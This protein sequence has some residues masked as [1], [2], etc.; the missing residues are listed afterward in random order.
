MTDN[1][2]YSGDTTINAGTLNIG[3]GGNSGSLYSAA[4][5]SGNLTFGSAGAI[6]NN[7]ILA[8]NIAGG[9]V[10]VNQTISGTGSLSVTGDQSVNFAGGTSITTT[11][12]QT[13]SASATSG[14][15]YGFNLAENATVTLTS[16]AGDI[17]MTGMIGTSNN[18]HTGNL[19]IDTSTGN[20]NVTLN[21]PTGV[22]ALDYGMNALTVTAGT[23][24]MTLGT[25][26]GLNWGTVHTISLTG[27]AIDST[28]NL[29]D[30]TTLTVNNSSTGTFSGNLTAGGGSLIKQG[31]GTLTLTG[32]ASYG[33]T[34]T[35]SA[36]TLELQG[37]GA[38]GG[39]TTMAGTYPSKVP[40]PCASPASA[41]TSTARHSLSTA[42]AAARLMPFP[43]ARA[44]RCSWA[45]TPSR[46]V[47]VPGTS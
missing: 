43:P 17:S 31:A 22:V 47:A 21:T 7:S 38:G 28:A 39:P 20:G 14:R 35:V 11:G 45:T 30:F 10:N 19:V 24:T 23:G 42:P 8:Y 5:S 13:Y 36:G 4:V 18:D 12:P 26:G 3:N 2:T 41:T 37:A 32:A 33:G 25:L 46:P 34:T 1:S 9:S 6:V 27:G 40:P 15:Y 16:T 29:N 44:A